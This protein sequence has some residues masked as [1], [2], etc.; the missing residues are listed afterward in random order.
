MTFQDMTSDQRAELGRLRAALRSLAEPAVAR[1]PKGGRLLQ[2]PSGI[3]LLTAVLKELGE[4]VLAREVQL[5][6]RDGDVLRLHVANR[7]LVRLGLPLP[8]DAGEKA[9]L[10]AGVGLSYAGATELETLRDVLLAFLGTETELGIAAVPL[11]RPLP[12]EE[13][14][15]AAETLAKVWA[16]PFSARVTSRAYAKPAATPVEAPAVD[17]SQP[18]EPGSSAEGGHMAARPQSA[19]SEGSAIAASSTVPDGRGPAE[20]DAVSSPRSVPAGAEPKQGTDLLEAFAARCRAFAIAEILLDG[21]MLLSEAGAE[22][23]LDQLRRW[24]AA[25]LPVAGAVDECDAAPGCLILRT[26]S[27]HGFVHA[28]VGMASLVIALSPGSVATVADLWRE[29]AGPM[30]AV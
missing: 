14:G 24:I 12:P 1:G 21:D 4:T 25:G 23:P 11:S 15:A 16:L 19:G 22:K 26:V 13:T 30:H 17:S 20:P 18:A 29:V 28:N 9:D 8:Q 5:I 3:D 10:V 2:A 6:R 27:G 7:R